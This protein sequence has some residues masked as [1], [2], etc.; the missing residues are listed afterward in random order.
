MM[1]CG[2]VRCRGI[3][4]RL[5]RVSFIVLHDRTR[6]VIYDIFFSF[7]FLQS[8]IELSSFK[9]IEIELCKL[10]VPKQ[11]AAIPK[12]L[13]RTKKQLLPT[14]KYSPITAGWS[15]HATHSLCLLM[16]A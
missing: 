5:L 6:T 4:Q 9:F 14:L 7:L 11:E 13:D 3:E 16:H 15:A 1:M 12:K 2:G 10:H 8:N